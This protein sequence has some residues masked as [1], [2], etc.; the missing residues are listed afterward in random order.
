MISFALWEFCLLNSFHISLLFFKGISNEEHGTFNIEVCEDFFV[1]FFVLTY[2]V[3]RCNN[4]N[5]CLSAISAFIS[6]KVPT[7]EIQDSEVLN[8]NLT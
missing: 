1:S 4:L 8:K 2:R 3:C 7:L 5:F 6:W